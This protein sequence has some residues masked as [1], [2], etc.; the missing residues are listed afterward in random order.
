MSECG[1]LIEAALAVLNEP[2]PWAKAAQTE[3]VVEAWRAGSLPILPS[4]PFQ[5]QTPDKPAR[6]PD[7]VKVVPSGRMPSLGRGGSLASQQVRSML[8]QLSCICLLRS[9]TGRSSTRTHCYSVNP[10]ANSA[11]YRVA[12]DFFG[13]S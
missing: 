10:T 12:G 4:A 2:D 6:S 8:M 3:R 11:E 13:L 5:L 7:V 9:T 1:S